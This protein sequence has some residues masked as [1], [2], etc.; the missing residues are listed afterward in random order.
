MK[1]ILILF[2][3]TLLFTTMSCAQNTN[4]NP[5]SET[6]QQDVTNDVKEASYAFGVD[7]GN[8]LKT[9]NIE[10]FDVDKFIE[11]FKAIYNDDG[12]IDINAN[13]TVIQN[14]MTA[15]QTKKSEKNKAE[16]AAFLEKNKDEE[17]VITTESGLQYKIEQQGTGEYPTAESEVEVNYRGTLIDGREFDSSYQRNETAKFPLNRVI[18]GWVEGIQK[19]NEGGKIK[20]FVPYDLAYG[21]RGGQGIEPYSTLIF[22]V[23]LIKIIK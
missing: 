5:Q 3:A 4:K 16:G 18:K 14:F 20:L 6:A 8:S 11:G 10:G 2:T 1:Q 15:L 7:V 12:K 22:E 19:I 23:E 21:E 13:R 9:Y 17:G